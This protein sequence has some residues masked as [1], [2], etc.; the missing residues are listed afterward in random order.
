M[1]TNKQFAVILGILL[2]TLAVSVPAYLFVPAPKETVKVA[3]FPLTIAGW[4]GKDLPVD[5][6]AFEILETHNLI[7]REYNRGKETVYLY[8]IYSQD[9]RK[10]SHPPEVCFEGSGITI[11]NKEKTPLELFDGKKISANELRVEKDGVVNLVLYWY[12]A[13]SF[14]TDNYLKQQAKIALG[15][16]TFKTTSN[17]MIRISTEVSQDNPGQ[18]LASLRSFLKD[19]SRY[20]PQIIP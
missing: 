19:A 16:L 6:R 8:V 12:K 14:Y 17:A 3:D 1:R 20:F 11:V 4:S 15:R 18:A 7:L 9:N 10:V 2:V 13:G 5:E